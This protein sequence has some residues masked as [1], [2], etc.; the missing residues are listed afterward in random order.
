MEDYIN[1]IGNSTITKNDYLLS[2]S[3]QI[4][5]WNPEVIPDEITGGIIGIISSTGSG[6]GVILKNILAV[7]HKKYDKI[8]LMSGTALLQKDMD[9]IPRENI[10][11]HYDDKIMG[12]LWDEQYD[13]K[14]ARRPNKR[15]LVILDDII[16]QKEFLRSTILPKI[17]CG[18]RHVNILVYLLSQHVTSL[19]PIIRENLRV[20][21]AFEFDNS[22]QLKIFIQEFLSSE[23][24]RVGKLLF[25]RITNV[26]YQ[27]II[28]SV[29]RKGKPINEKVM[30]FIA[31]PKIKINMTKPKPAY[32]F[33][34]FKALKEPEEE[35][36][37]PPRRKMK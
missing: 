6:K 1:N 9:Y 26:P 20:V 3:Y 24:N 2:E 30:R 14:L 8:I 5:E 10:I 16:H 25:K 28:I 32:M 4:D 37:P 33:P 34:M 19:S 15:I 29:Y 21:I 31:D 22:Q 13:N 7:T 35:T 36:K 11:D 27:A 18:A 12:D 17:S 23:N